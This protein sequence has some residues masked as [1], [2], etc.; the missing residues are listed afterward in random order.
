MKNLL[1][2]RRRTDEIGA[3]HYRS[4]RK[5]MILAAHQRQMRTLLGKKPDLTLKELRAAVALECSLPAIHYALA[6]MGL[7]YISEQVNLFLSVA[8]AKS[9]FTHLHS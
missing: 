6:K 9:L 8:R 4:G 5:P 3:R 1:Q 2:Q 7:T